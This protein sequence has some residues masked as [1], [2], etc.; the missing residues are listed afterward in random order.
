MVRRQGS[1]SS[2]RASDLKGS[3]LPAHR[4]ALL[5]AIA[6]TTW[7]VGAGMAPPSMLLPS[8]HGSAPLLDR[9]LVIRAKVQRVIDGDT[10]KV[11]AFGSGPPHHI[12]QLIGIDAPEL[13]GPECG[14]TN[15]T[16]YMRRIA[17]RGRHVTLRTDPSRGLF[18]LHSRLVA[19]VDTPSGSLQAKMLRVGW[20]TVHARLGRAFERIG[21]FRKIAAAARHRHRGAWRRCGGDFHRPA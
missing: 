17:W 2:S 18:D 7:T 11:R 5:G 1:G 12:V 6:L 20:A 14:G 4:T 19:Y 10:I 21:R 15:A 9:S 8:A 13:L 16:D 3:Q